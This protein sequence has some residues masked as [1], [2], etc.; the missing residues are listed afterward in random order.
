[1]GE[2]RA[3][4][5]SHRRVSSS[6]SSVFGSSSTEQILSLIIVNGC[7]VE[8]TILN[9]ICTTLVVVLRAGEVK[10]RCYT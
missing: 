5:V 3:D 9:T 10:L 7:H 4:F 2:E 6:V 8:E 1:M